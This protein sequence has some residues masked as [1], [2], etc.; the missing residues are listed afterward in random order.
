ME[1]EKLAIHTN[2]VNTKQTA[3]SPLYNPDVL[4]HMLLEDE[5]LRKLLKKDDRKVDV[6]KFE[7]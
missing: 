1:W 2:M 5:N 3:M 7:T 4:T 6:L